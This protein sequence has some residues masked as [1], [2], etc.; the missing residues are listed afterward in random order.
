M[1]KI[2]RSDGAQQPAG[3]TQT[4]RREQAADSA[5]QAAAAV[6]QQPSSPRQDSF[7]TARAPHQ[8]QRIKRSHINSALNANA[9]AAQRT[10]A[11]AAADT[12]PRA[13]AATAPRPVQETGQAPAAAEPAQSARKEQQAAEI[14]NNVYHAI[15]AQEQQNASAEPAAPARPRK[16]SADRSGR[17]A[18]GA[19]DRGGK[20]SSGWVYNLLMVVFG[21]VFLI[22][23][24]ML[25]NRLM[26]DRQSEDAFSGVAALI[27]TPAPDGSAAAP[28]DNAAKFARLKEKNEDFEG[29]IAIEG[30]NLNY[31][32]MYHPSEIDYYLRKDFYKNYSN[33]GTPY[34]D[35]KCTLD[36]LS[37]NIIIYGHNMKT[38]TI[39]GCLTEY[40]KESY[41][42]EHPFIQFDTMA[43]DGKYRVYAAF[44]IDV[45][46]D[47]SF[48]YNTY[49]DMDE[50]AFN[51]FVAECKRRSAVDS[52]YTPAYGD[53]LLTLSTCEYSTSD[54]RFVVCAYKVEE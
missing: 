9:A 45:V 7:G 52:G 10:Q 53:Q 33:Y 44:A 20:K 26:Q 29:W 43:G 3:Q 5:R 51:E 14:S 19:A 48:P 12:T 17:N 46:T 42:E 40:K 16:K 49:V 8:T 37:N 24:G 25:V 6:P 35:E 54:G 11:Y 34:I 39:F 41:Y 15:L 2:K 36:P 1:A 32:V 31:P 28:E 4:F 13:A 23:G 30:T 38:G 27:E 18:G 47:T 22:S 21:A 50:A